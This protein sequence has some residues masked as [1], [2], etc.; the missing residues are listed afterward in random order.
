MSNSK[1]PGSVVLKHITWNQAIS[2]LA[3]KI[4]RGQVPGFYHRLTDK[5]K[6][7][8]VL[9]KIHWILCTDRIGSPRHAPSSPERPCSWSILLLFV[10]CTAC[11]C[12]QSGRVIDCFLRHWDETE[13]LPSTL[14][15]GWLGRNCF[16]SQVNLTLGHLL[17]LVL[18][19]HILF[20]WH[21][22][23]LHHRVLNS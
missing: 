2:E 19:I 13:I 12:P 4:L 8:Q 22:F 5:L 7:V 10:V 23:L 16:G 6:C 9:G 11:K 17:S 3:G 15:W 20:G 14:Y 21:I 18:S 1:A